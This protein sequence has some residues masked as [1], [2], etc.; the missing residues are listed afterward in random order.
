MKKK[1]HESKQNKTA[2][3][4]TT[5]MEMQRK[6]VRLAMHDVEKTF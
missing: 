2:I 1:A 5:K 4:T 3:K 6:V